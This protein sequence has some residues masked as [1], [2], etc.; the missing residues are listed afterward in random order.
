MVWLVPNYL[1]DWIRHDPDFVSLRE[2]PE[3]VRMFG[4]G[5]A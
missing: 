4:S 5:E 1:T 3:F 2:H